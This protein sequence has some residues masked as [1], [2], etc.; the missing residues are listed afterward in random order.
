[1]QINLSSRLGENKMKITSPGIRLFAKIGAKSF[2]LW[3]KVLGM[4]LL[5]SCICLLVAGHLLGNNESAGFHGSGIGA[6]VGLLYLFYG[7]FWPTL[8]FFSS[9][10]FVILYFI[11]ANKIALMNVVYL[12][13]ENKST[14]FISPMVVGYLQKIYNQHSDW[15]KG[16]VDNSVLLKAL[17]DICKSDSSSYKIQ[18]KIIHY[19]L[20]KIR[21]DDVDLQDEKLN[22]PDVITQKIIRMISDTAKPSMKPFWIISCIQSVLAVL[23]IFFDHH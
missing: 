11:V 5:F 6:I 21:L 1:M 13:W 20:K 7:D 3:I 10:I 2:L 9:I 15:I 12:T 8:L 19:G 22:L 23:A 16:R 18:R 17:I 4:G 14:Q